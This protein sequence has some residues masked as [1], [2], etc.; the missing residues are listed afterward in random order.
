MDV[1][2]LAIALSDTSAK[3]FNKILSMIVANTIFNNNS[4]EK[5]S[6]SEIQKDIKTTYDLEFSTTEIESAVSDNNFFLTYKENNIVFVSLST[7]M[8]AK[9]QSSL[10]NVIDLDKC[11]Q[12]FICE[13]GSSIEQICEI[14]TDAIKELINRFVYYSFNEDISELTHL[15]Q[16]SVNPKKAKQKKRFTTNEIE[17]IKLF[18]DWDNDE[19]NKFVFDIVR[20]AYDYCILTTKQNAE[21]SMFSHN[22]FYLDTNVIFSLTGINGKERMY[23]TKTFIKK[24]KDLYSELFYTSETANEC[25]STLN[26]LVNNMAS[27]IRKETYFTYEALKTVF[28]SSNPAAL[29]SLYTEWIDGKPSRNGDY[30]GFLN[31]MINQLNDTLD[32][33]RLM[34]IERKF[35]QEKNV[36]INQ[37]KESI[38]KYKELLNRKH[39]DNAALVDAANYCFI[40]SIRNKNTSTISNQNIFFI[41]MDNALCRWASEQCAG[42]INVFISPGIMYSLMLRFSTRT[43]NDYKSFNNFVSLRFTNDFFAENNVWAKEEMIEEINNLEM[44]DNAKKTIL[45]AANKETA[46]KDKRITI[47]QFMNAFLLIILFV[48]LTA[49]VFM[50]SLQP[51]SYPLLWALST[52]ASFSL[53]FS[54]SNS[55]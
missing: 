37:S 26:N 16:G 21:E 10:N 22:K 53:S 38:V 18:L 9:I 36:L 41:S 51:S 15:I 55:S 3:R 19:K 39:S 45:Y 54:S 5:M 50:V 8:N 27:I 2:R 43:K 29:Y 20:A 28:P 4:I 6:C 23:S 1:L 11:V 48:L 52:S 35:L 24:C 32:S 44:P 42:Y 40:D 33:L 13:N 7:K 14:N 17:I 25:K 31:H 34:P 30:N 46:I 12:L 47:D 49:I